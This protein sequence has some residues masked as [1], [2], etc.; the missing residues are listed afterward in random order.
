MDTAES[1]PE[2]DND[3]KLGM[4]LLFNCQNAIT[5]KR[6]R[7]LNQQGDPVALWVLNG[8]ADCG[9]DCFSELHATFQ[10]QLAIVDNQVGLEFIVK[11]DRGIVATLLFNDHVGEFVVKEFRK[12]KLGFVRVGGSR[13]YWQPEGQKPL[14]GKKAIPALVAEVNRLRALV[15]ESP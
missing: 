5:V 13:L 2:D 6:L 9:V 10:Q 3:E 11:D 14:F 1:S 12:D 4:F 7:E 8:I 15:K